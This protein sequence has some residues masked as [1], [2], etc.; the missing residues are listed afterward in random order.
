L[1][2]VAY[3]DA[4]SGSLIVSAI[5]AGFAGIAVVFKTGFRRLGLLFSPR[6][7][8]EARVAREAASDPASPH[9]V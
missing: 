9:E 5:V 4:G 2:L 3:L 8:R 7:R 1:R 6:R